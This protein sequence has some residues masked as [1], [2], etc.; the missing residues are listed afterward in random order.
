MNC[1]SQAVNS[2]ITWLKPNAK[3]I[4]LISIIVVAGNYI[5]K[6]LANEKTSPEND[7]LVRYRDDRGVLQRVQ[8][9]SCAIVREVKNRWKRRYNPT[10]INAPGL[11]PTLQLSTN[12]YFVDEQKWKE[13]SKFVGLIHGLKGSP[14]VWTNYI[15]DIRKSD[16][17]AICFVPHVFKKGYCKCKEAA[18]PILNVVKKYHDVCPDNEIV[19]IGHSLGGE[20]A[21]YIQRKLNIG[22]IRVISI[23]APH[24]GSILINWMDTLH[25]A[26]WFG[27][28]ADMVK[29]LSYGGNLSTK[30]LI[31]WKNQQTKNSA[32]EG[33]KRVFFATLNDWRVFPIA[34]SCPKLPNSHYEW[35]SGESHVTIIDAVREKVLSYV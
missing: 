33:V 12:T 13:S 10:R 15:E 22:N 35:V 1:I 30:K 32:D 26:S 5:I 14:L 16:K 3:P 25:V 34:V 21:A 11:F 2:S 18:R 7:L 23:A 19:L 28:S 9:G 31:Q 24:G 8:D 6:K 4:V 27:I 20:M 17:N 29:E